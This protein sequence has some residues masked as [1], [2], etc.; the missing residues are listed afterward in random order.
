MNSGTEGLFMQVHDV[1][2][3][4]RE[5][6]AKVTSVAIVM[7]VH[8]ARSRHVEL[9]DSIPVVYLRAVAGT[10]PDTRHDQRKINT[11]RHERALAGSGSRVTAGVIDAKNTH[12]L[13][14][15]VPGM[16]MP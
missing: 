3:R 11:T 16:E 14:L 9:D 12:A 10:R 2:A 13:E 6:T 15:I 1:W 5:H 8:V 4:L 7:A